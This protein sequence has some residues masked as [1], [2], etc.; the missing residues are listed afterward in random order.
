MKRKGTLP[1]HTASTTSLVRTCADNPN[2]LFADKGIT[3]YKT[4]KMWDVTEE[5]TNQLASKDYRENQSKSIFVIHYPFSNVKSYAESNCGIVS[6]LLNGKYLE[7][8]V[9][10]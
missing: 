9:T 10:D 3:T 1:T 5:F 6:K 8:K 7:G 4:L 2:V